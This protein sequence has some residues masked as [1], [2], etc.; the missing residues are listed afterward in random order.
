MNTVGDAYW[1]PQAHM[2]TA[3]SRRLVITRGEGIWLETS[4]G[5]RLIDATSSLWHANIGHGRERLARA[6]Y[7]QMTKLETYH[8]FGRTVNEPALQLADWL[9]AEA[10][11]AGAKVMLTSGGSDSVDLACKLARRHW[12]LEG[13]PGK[14]LIL[15]RHN[16]YHGLHA[17]GTS[18][19]GLGYNREGYGADSLVPETARISTND[20]AEV[21]R[22]VLQLGPENIAAIIAEPVIG[23]GGVVGPAEGYLEGL[24]ALCRQHDIL[25]I[26]DEVIT[27]FGRTGH[28]FASQRWGIVPDIVTMA[29]GITSGYA[30]LGGVLVAP[31]VADRFFTGPDAPIFRHGLT[32][33]GHATACVVA[34]ANLEVL[35]EESLVEEAGRLEAVLELM[36]KPLRDSELVV[37]VR[38]GAGFMAG[39]QLREEVDADRIID[40]CQAS[41]VLIRTI[42]DNTLQICPPFICTDDDVAQIVD[43]IDGALTSYGGPR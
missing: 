39:V 34:M 27:G 12:Q 2:P 11:M 13:R 36:V 43:A 37:D 7:D 41:G 5:E 24:E 20:L 33:S 9:A 31:R 19:A 3:R 23:T 1:N 22:S 14:K 29:K 18:V 40:A 32:Y 25:F 17:F 4:S 26:A 10:P 8:T 16:G 42:H 30:P 6:A 38:A 21:G 28:M 15:S 35:A